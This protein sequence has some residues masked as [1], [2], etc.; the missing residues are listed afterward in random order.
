MTQT[1]TNSDESNLYL[2]KDLTSFKEVI[3]IFYVIHCT[4]MNLLNSLNSLNWYH[5]V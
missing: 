1:V 5:F 3:G 2:S 4:L